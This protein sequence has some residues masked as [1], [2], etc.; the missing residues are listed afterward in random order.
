MSLGKRRV[1]LEQFRHFHQQF[2]TLL[3]SGPCRY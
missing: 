3:E 2:L 1:K